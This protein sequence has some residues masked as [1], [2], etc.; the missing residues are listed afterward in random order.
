MIPLSDRVLGRASGP[1]RSRDNSGGGLQFVSWKSVRS[2]RVFP[3]KGIYRRKGDVRG[4]PGAHTTWWRGQGWPAPP[5]GAAASW[6]SSVSPLD[7]VFL[8]GK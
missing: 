4:G 7:S 3:T 5:Y 2:L 1:S 8:L 6:S